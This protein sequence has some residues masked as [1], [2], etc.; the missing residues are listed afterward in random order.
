MATLN[1]KEALYRT[2]T[3]LLLVANI[4]K[5]S[6]FKK[7]TKRHDYAL[8]TRN[9]NNTQIISKTIYFFSAT[10]DLTFPFKIPL[11]FYINVQKHNDIDKQCVH[12]VYFFQYVYILQC[13][14]MV[15]YL[16]NC[17]ADN[18]HISWHSFIAEL[19]LQL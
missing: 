9:K 8:Q 1:K 13:G 17:V 4:E 18:V 11:P 2:H 5:K 12:I 3:V 14:I 10:R 19:C 7:S 15:T 6:I 16:G